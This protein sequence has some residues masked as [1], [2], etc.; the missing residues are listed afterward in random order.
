MLYFS[1]TETRVLV[2]QIHLEFNLLK[3][4]TYSLKHIQSSLT[5]YSTM[6][7]ASERDCSFQSC[8]CFYNFQGLCPSYKFWIINTPKGK[9]G[10]ML[11]TSSA[12][13]RKLQKNQFTLL[14]F[15]IINNLPNIF[16]KHILENRKIKNGLKFSAFI[17]VVSKNI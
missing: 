10:W 11:K 9:S 7:H 3:C 12:W 14:K 2:C 17:Y 13:R 16:N 5:V 15:Y 8:F 4:T 1:D 6:V